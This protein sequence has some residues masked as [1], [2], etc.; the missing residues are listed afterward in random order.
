MCCINAKTEQFCHSCCSLDAT[1][2][3]ISIG[4]RLPPVGAIGVGAGK[5]LG[6]R[7]I[8][9]QILPNAPKT[10]L[11]HFC[12][13]IFSHKEQEALFM[14]W[15]Q[16]KRP[17]HGMTSKK[18][19]MC[20][21]AIHGRH[22]FKSNN[23]GHHLCLDF[24]GY[25]CCDRKSRAA[26]AQS[27][28]LWQ[29]ATIKFTCH[30]HSSR[31]LLLHSRTLLSHRSHVLCVKAELGTTFT[32]WSQHHFVAIG[33]PE[34]ICPKLSTVAASNNRLHMPWSLLAYAIVTFNRWH[35]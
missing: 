19:F 20:F 24:L 28:A 30:D 15:P 29:Q 2:P 11:C 31:T 18:V 10:F 1:Q 8:F 27:F 33:N 34:G 17:F 14:V 21:S 22:F 12:L 23:F 6:V 13:Q 25:Y 16:K 7:R 5:C 9:A 32:S 4:P 26:Y 3:R 35:R